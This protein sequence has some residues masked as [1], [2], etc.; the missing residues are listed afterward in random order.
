MIFGGIAKNKKTEEIRTEKIT[1]D[2]QIAA[3]PVD[4]GQVMR[5]LSQ[6]KGKL[7]ITFQKN[8]NPLYESLCLV[9]IKIPIYGSVVDIVR[10]MIQTDGSNKNPLSKGKLAVDTK[11]TN[12]YAF[13]G[14]IR[15]KSIDK[16][17]TII[18]ALIER[19]RGILKSAIAIS[20]RDDIGNV[21]IKP[22]IYNKYTKTTPHAFFRGGKYVND[23][24]DDDDEN[25]NIGNRE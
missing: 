3:E 10:S 25:D 22:R 8:E 2:A 4:L 16:S 17:A 6:S 7:E 20:K 5:Y 11:D 23:I 18:L 21:K 13:V 15:I 12:L 14:A 19:M 1:I 24:D 9:F